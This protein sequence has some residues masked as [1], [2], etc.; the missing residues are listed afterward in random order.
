[1][2][3]PR[4]RVSTARRA[5]TASTDTRA[6]APTDS[7]VDLRSRADRKNLVFDIV[8]QK[9][10]RGGKTR[11]LCGA[12]GP[13]CQQEVNECLAEPCENDAECVDRLAGF[14]C[15]CPAGFTVS[16]STSVLF[17]LPR[18]PTFNY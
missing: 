15:L 12:A 17:S 13:E 7:S 3:A 2:S 18:V 14:L 9:L 8:F 4:L 16:T 10:K 6:S 11:F 5:W 1:M